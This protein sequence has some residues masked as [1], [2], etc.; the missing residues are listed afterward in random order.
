MLRMS[1]IMLEV[2][3]EPF[4]FALVKI[5]VCLTYKVPVIAHYQKSKSLRFVE[6]WTDRRYKIVSNYL[7]SNQYPFF[8]MVSIKVVLVTEIW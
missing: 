6:P 8:E 3:P 7:L 4:N 2:N 5:E 1:V